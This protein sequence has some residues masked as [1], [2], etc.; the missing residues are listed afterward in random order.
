MGVRR[1]WLSSSVLL[2]Y[3]FEKKSLN[4]SGTRLVVSS[5]NPPAS[6][7]SSG[8]IRNI[9]SDIQL[10][11]WVLGSKRRSL[12]SHGKCFYALSHCSSTHILFFSWETEFYVALWLCSNSSHSQG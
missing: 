3:S 9:S 6:A 8:R 11:I 2:S 7:S 4:E 1:C 10:L 5:S 12:W